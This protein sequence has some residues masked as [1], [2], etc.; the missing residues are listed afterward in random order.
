MAYTFN[1]GH[2]WD[3]YK[4]TP[5]MEAAYEE[6]FREGGGVGGG[7]GGGGEDETTM[8]H[9]ANDTGPRFALEFYLRSRA[10]DVFQGNPPGAWT[11]AIHKPGTFP[12]ENDFFQLEPSRR[13][14]VV[15]W[16]IVSYMGTMV[17]N[18][19]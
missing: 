10:L 18:A 13:Y 9:M 19:C 2:F 11:V 3:V 5:A 1:A 7:G 4:R 12:R 17:T 8:I 6:M 16:C 14:M 15:P